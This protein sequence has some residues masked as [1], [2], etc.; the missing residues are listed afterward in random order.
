MFLNQFISRNLR[1]QSSYKPLAF[2]FCTQCFYPSACWH[3]F[4]TD[5]K[6]NLELVKVSHCIQSIFYFTTIATILTIWLTKLLLLI[7]LQTTLLTSMYHTM[8]S[9][10]PALKRHF[11]WIWYCGKKIKI[12]FSVVFTLTNNDTSYHSDDNLYCCQ[13]CFTEPMSQMLL[14]Q[15]LILR[16]YWR[17]FGG[18]LLRM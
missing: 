10:V 4:W 1:S 8:P 18:A 13:C 16:A 9:S 7:R 17:F 11:L 3:T 5:A 2:S 12:W 6:K 15:R 14:A